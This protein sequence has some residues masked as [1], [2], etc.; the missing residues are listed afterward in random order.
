ME[1]VVEKNKVVTV[2]YHVLQAALESKTLTFVATLADM[3]DAAPCEI[4]QRLGA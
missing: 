2:E 3:R 4:A 1:W